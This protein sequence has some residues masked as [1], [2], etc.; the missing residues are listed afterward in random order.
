[1]VLEPIKAAAKSLS[2]SQNQ[3]PLQSPLKRKTCQNVLSLHY[4]LLPCS[5]GVEHQVQRRTRGCGRDAQ[6]GH[7]VPRVAVRANHHQSPVL[8]SVREVRPVSCARFPS[9]SDD[10]SLAHRPC[11]F[12]VVSVSEVAVVGPPDLYRV[13]FQTIDPLA[14]MSMAWVR[15]PNNLTRLLPICFAVN[16]NRCGAQ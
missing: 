15:S 4:F 14:M 5:G 8:V 3:T 16:S 1:M 6:R 7:H 9:V 13:G 12:S 10:D 2:P 11:F